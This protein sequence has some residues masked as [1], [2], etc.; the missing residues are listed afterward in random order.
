MGHLGV[1]K[2]PGL[3]SSDV[4]VRLWP[5][6]RG[7]EIRAPGSLRGS[8]SPPRGRAWCPSVGLGRLPTSP[9]S[10][11]CLKVAGG[12]VGLGHRAP[13][14][15]TPPCP[16]DQFQTF[17]ERLREPASG[18]GGVLSS[19]PTA[20]CR[21]SALLALGLP[22]PLKGPHSSPQPSGLWGRREQGQFQDYFALGSCLPSPFPLGSGWGGVGLSEKDSLITHLRGP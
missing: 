21:T 17:L 9:P 18:L 1:G 16:W 4:A 7:A 5:R 6:G 2:G 10:C 3:C 12:N 8:A 14:Q 19:T 22:V 13:L 20:F 11:L 15:P